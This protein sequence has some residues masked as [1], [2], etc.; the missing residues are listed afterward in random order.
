M[1]GTCAACGFDH[2][3]LQIVLAADVRNCAD[4][5]FCLRCFAECIVSLGRQLGVNMIPACTFTA[6]LIA[7]VSF[8][9]QGVNLE[10][11][12]FPIWNH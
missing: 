8:L 7:A 10:K 5:S 9:I 6:S 1:R 3:S 2:H 12:Y 4:G 11:A